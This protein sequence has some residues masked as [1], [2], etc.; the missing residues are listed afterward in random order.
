MF[1][2]RRKQSAHTLYRAL[3][4]T[5]VA[6]VA[7]GIYLNSFPL[8]ID[9]NQ[10][11]ADGVNLTREGE[12]DILVVIDYEA[13]RS[14]GPGFRERDFSAAWINLFEQV[15][16]PV[17]IATP[18]TVSL[19]KITEAR[20]IVLTSSVSDQVPE[21]MLDQLREHALKGNTIVVERPQGKLRDTFSANG[22]A[23]VREAQAFTFARDLEAPYNAQLLDMPLSTQFVGSTAPRA[24]ATTHLSVDGAPAIY[25]IPIGQGTAI[26]VDFDFGEQMVAM[27]QGRPTE[28]F[29]VHPRSD[30]PTAGESNAPKTSALIMDPKLENNRVP[31]ADLLE[32]FV[33]YGVIAK[34]AP[35][36]T[37]W[38]FPNGAAGALI[39]VH[40]D[41]ELGDD[42][43]WMLDYETSKNATSTLLSTVDAGLSASKAAVLARKGAELGLSY[44]K[45]GTPLE[46]DKRVGFWGF[47]PIA[48]PIGLSDQL[49]SLRKTLPSNSIRSVRITDSWWD[50]EWSKPF[51]VMAAQN[52]RIDTSYSPASGAGYAFGTGFPFLTVNAQGQVLGI[53]EMPVVFPGDTPQSEGIPQL[54]ELIEESAQGHHEAITWSVSPSLFADYPDMQRFERWLAVFE[55]AEKHDHIITS[56]IQ[57]DGFMRARRASKIKSRIIHDAV[58][59][60][61]NTLERAVAAARAERKG[62]RLEKAEVQTATLLRISVNAT[63][64]NITLTVPATL[65]GKSFISAQKGSGQADPNFA[66]TQIETTRVTMVGYPLVQIPLDAGFSTLNIYYK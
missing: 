56:A 13:I 44:Q 60:S 29:Q 21:Q 59:P 33:L 57:F 55:L 20:V 14:S 30:Q 49:S 25:S 51:E 45:P 4:W 32:R 2:S 42:G 9:A 37:M 52:L 17:A 7:G 28:G 12:V 6:L 27:Q 19:K 5:F 18:T 61:G 34:Y 35:M 26:T 64:R 53:R 63:Q 66:A 24:G 38:P 65:E 62:E 3:L 16:G 15:V 58:L 54:A 23:G 43:G 40:E 36:P 1:E 50:S 48:Q 10:K 22:R 47:K 41:R 46:L 8:V 11:I 39:A 31:Y